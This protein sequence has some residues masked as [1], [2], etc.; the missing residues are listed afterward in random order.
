MFHQLC[1]LKTKPT[2][3]ADQAILLLNHM[4]ADDMEKPWLEHVT[5]AVC[6]ET[7]DEQAGMNI[8][9][10]AYF[11]G[12]QAS[13]LK[14]PTIVALLPM[15]RDGT[16]S[17]AMVKHGMDIIAQITAHVNPGQIPVV[18]VNQPLYALD[19][20][21]QWAWPD[22]Y[23]E[24]KY[25]IMMGG[26]H[27]EMAMLSVIWDWLSGSG[28]TYVMASANIT[29]EGRALGVQKGSHTSRAQWA[30]QVTVV[31]LFGLLKKSYSEYCNITPDNEQLNFEEWSKHMASAHPQYDYWYKVLQLECLF[32]QFLRSQCDQQYE[33]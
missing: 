32:L 15:F 25:V 12:L 21:I 5:S 9:W 17:P 13:L 22:K 28:W 2:T 20:K 16:H 30:H 4:D 7:Q 10:S 31:A 8:T 26:L 23:C 14:P 11:A 33:R 27:I 24:T 3:T 18:T 29:T 6:S 19:K 1:F